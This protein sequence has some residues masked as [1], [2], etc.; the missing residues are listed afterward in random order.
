[1]K[2]RCEDKRLELSILFVLVEVKEEITSQ[3]QGSSLALG[4]SA[5]TLR[6]EG[7]GPTTNRLSANCLKSWEMAPP[8]VHRKESIPLLI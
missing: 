5:H 1:M 3:E 8:C 7:L 6:R 2:G 4:W